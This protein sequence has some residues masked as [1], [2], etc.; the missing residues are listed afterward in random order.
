MCLTSVVPWYDS[1]SSARYSRLISSRYSGFCSRSLAWLKTPWQVLQMVMM[2]RPIFSAL[3]KVRALMGSD[4]CV[5]MHPAPVHATSVISSSSRSSLS[6]TLT[7][8]E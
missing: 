2:G 4:S 1:P 3:A 5:G 7:A 8:A 6:A